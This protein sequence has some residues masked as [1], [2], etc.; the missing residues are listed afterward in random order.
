MHQINHPNSGQK[1]WLKYDYS[2]THIFVKGTIMIT[3]GLAAT[4][5]ATRLWDER[6]EMAISK[7]CAPFTDCIKEIN[8]G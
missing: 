8:N 5:T 3:L 7:T 4:D 1:L 2:D 6:N